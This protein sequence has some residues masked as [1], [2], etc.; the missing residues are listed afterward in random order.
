MRICTDLCGYSLPEADN[1]RKIL[2]KKKKSKMIEEEPKFIAGAIE[3]GMSRADAKKLF[4]D[5]KGYAE[6]LFCSA[7]SL[8]YSIITYQTAYLKAHYPVHFY[9]ALLARE[10]NPD[11][12]I[13]YACSI[14]EAGIEI[15]PPDI[16]LSD[17]VHRP[18]EGSIR[19]GLSHIKG[20]PLA[21]AEEIVRI[22]EEK[23]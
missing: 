16:N 4:A 6:Y 12:I 14:R 21:E 22:R 20:M 10:K 7:H 17:V 8:S 13:Q 1:M 5:I 3:S 19:F 15:L 23:P 2:G 9:A 11:M 18:E